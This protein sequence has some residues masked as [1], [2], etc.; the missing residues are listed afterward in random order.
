MAFVLVAL[1]MVG[2]PGG[3]ITRPVALTVEFSGLAQCEQAR[4]NLH[5][6][7]RIDVVYASCERK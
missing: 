3:S 2:H 7:E 5:G 1:I 6:R 4:R